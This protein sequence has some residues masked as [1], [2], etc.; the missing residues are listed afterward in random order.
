MPLTGSLLAAVIDGL[1]PSFA[2]GM[3]DAALDPTRRYDVE[4]VPPA[5][6]ARL[7]DGG[8]LAA[9]VDLPAVDKVALNAMRNPLT[10]A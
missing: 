6:A 5:F 9:L 2:E 10:P 1:A 3:R 7:V 4:L 8:L